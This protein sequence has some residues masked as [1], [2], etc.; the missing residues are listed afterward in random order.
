MSRSPVKSRIQYGKSSDPL[1]GGEN[2]KTATSRA[3]INRATALKT[4]GSFSS[5]SSAPAKRNQRSTSVS[6]NPPKMDTKML[7]REDNCLREHGIVR[8]KVSTPFKSIND[9]IEIIEPKRS[10]SSNAAISKSNVSNEIS[11][12]GTALS[13][14]QS[15]F[16][17]QLEP[18]RY[19]TLFSVCGSYSA[20]TCVPSSA[21]IWAANSSNGCIDIFSACTGKLISSFP[22]T[23]LLSKSNVSTPKRSEHDIPINRFR[24]LC[25]EESTI[26]KP[27][28]LHSTSTHVWIGYSNGNVAIFDHLVHAV[29]TEGCF[30]HAPVVAFSSFPD[31][32]TVSGSAEG[33]LVHWDCEANNFEAVTRIKNRDTPHE[34]LSS[35]CAGETCWVVITG[36]ESGV[37]HITDMSNGKHSVSQRHHS[38]KVTSVV[39]LGEL[40]FST[41]EDELVN[42]WRFDVSAFPLTTYSLAGCGGT[43][44]HSLRL[45][46]QIAVH[47][48]VCSLS[49]DRLRNSIWVSYVDGLIERWSAHPDDSFGVEE[50]IR[51]GV[52]PHFSDNEAERRMTHVFPFTSVE[53]LQILALSNNGINNVWYG[54]YNVLEAKV[55]QSVTTMNRII[56][57]DAA[58]TAIWREKIEDLQKRERKRK[59]RYICILEELNHQ[60]LMRHAYESW[61]CIVTKRRSKNPKG[62]AVRQKANKVALLLKTV[63]FKLLQQYFIPWVTCHDRFKKHQLL[64]H[65]AEMLESASLC[66]LQGIVLRKWML[67]LV[68][69]RLRM[70]SVHCVTAVER[71]NHSAFLS[72]FYFKWYLKTSEKKNAVTI[73]SRAATKN[74]LQVVESQIH[75]R[76]LQKSMKKWHHAYHVLPNPTKIQAFSEYS[77][78]ARFADVYEVINKE[79][80]Q[81]TFFRQWREWAA[82]RKHFH[83]LFPVSSLLLRRVQYMQMQR[84]YLLWKMFTSSRHIKHISDEISHVGKQIQEIEQDNKDVIQKREYKKKIEELVLKKQQ[85]VVELEAIEARIEKLFQSIRILCDGSTA[86]NLPK[87]T[88]I[89]T[90]RINISLSAPMSK[91]IEW[92]RGVLFQQRLL[93]SVLFQMPQQKAL[94]HV[95]SQLKGTVINLYT[96]KGLLLHVKELHKSGNKCAQEIFVESF[97]EVKNLM[98]SP[99]RKNSRQKVSSSRWLLYMETLDSIPLH[100]CTPLLQAIKEM[101]I[102]FDFLSLPCLET[103]HEITNE[104]IANAD[105]L[106]L[107]FRACHLRRRPVSQSHDSF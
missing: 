31:G 76:I 53:T 48:A 103:L 73:S 85:E 98:I 16:G 99:S 67:F 75:R 96:D 58:D 79:R 66:L 6:L 83:A 42:I 95:M 72:R 68:Q 77:P 80:T 38:R 17:E 21:S 105:W 45:L 2:W 86:K 57:Q 106:F 9:G 74:Q 44:I 100:Y 39:V 54:H 5:L 24:Y 37:I 107:I 43:Q 19:Q 22:P 88:S 18:N 25:G 7:V 87:A 60:R 65:A 71:A 29:V 52:L 78:L 8:K 84:A 20:I 59:E 11:F 64:I 91:N 40:A 61:R 10:T 104:I 15:D 1:T 27:T 26:P 90:N 102:A 101:I 30:H 51:E 63:N 3:S 89:T 97:K 56:S 69:K 14:L 47:P 13:P 4:S 28:A 70:A 32:T 35:V 34:V 62:Q 33:I 23:V 41:G 12:L 82:R 93:P 50:V 46:R 55:N 94:H 81:Q 49:L 92:Y 36:F